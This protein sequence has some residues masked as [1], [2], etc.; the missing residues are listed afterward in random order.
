MTACAQAGTEM[1]GASGTGAQLGA[2][3]VFMPQ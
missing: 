1:P 2:Y 3:L